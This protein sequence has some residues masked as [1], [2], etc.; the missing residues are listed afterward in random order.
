[1]A[2]GTTQE[3]DLLGGQPGSAGG[4]PPSTSP[5]APDF[6]SL[7]F[8]ESSGK[9]AVRGR[10]DRSSAS[11]LN[12]D[13]IVK[14]VTGA[15]EERDFIAALLYQQLGD[16]DT[17]HYRHEVFR[18]LEDESLLERIQQFADLMSKVRSHLGQVEKMQYLHQ[19]EGWFLDAASIYCDAV[20]ALADGL[21][22]AR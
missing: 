20:R 13:Q 12:L 21:S 11:D 14:T 19:R 18:D 5:P 15:R 6:T 4:G 2:D 8:D 10:E 9:A 16:I 22:S 7:L 1:M 17:V 3:P